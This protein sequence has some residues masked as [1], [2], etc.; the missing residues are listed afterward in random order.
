[1]GW[2]VGG[3]GKWYTEAAELWTHR[4]GSLSFFRQDPRS[5]WGS[6]GG[7]QALSPS[8]GLGAGLATWVPV[9]RV[10]CPPPPHNTLPV[11]E[12]G[13][14]RR[15]AVNVLP[16][17]LR[18]HHDSRVVVRV[19]PTG[20]W[21]WFGHIFSLRRQA[22]CFLWRRYLLF[23]GWGRCCGAHACMCM[24]VRVCTCGARCTVWV[25]GGFVQERRPSPGPAHAGQMLSPALPQEGCGC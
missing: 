2:G 16:L 25:A 5:R 14:W 18:G 21:V 11:W 23:P 4:Q 12:A 24:Y 15:G 9:H 13:L 8:W 10:L 17:N 19:R 3:R 6:P 20:S 7:L 22:C 1:M